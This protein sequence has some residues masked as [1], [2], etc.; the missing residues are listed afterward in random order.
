MRL[1][2]WSP[3]KGSDSGR[4]NLTKFFM[5]PGPLPA[6]S[7]LQKVVRGPAFLGGTIPEKAMQ[8]Y[9][10]KL[11][12][13]SSKFLFLRR[14]SA[15]VVSTKGHLYVIDSMSFFFWWDTFAQARDSMD[16]G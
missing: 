11:S 7:C 10:Q 5:P 15:P 4:A 9:G 8:S 14:Y 13:F 2:P 3:A 12:H 1:N 16:I 6:F